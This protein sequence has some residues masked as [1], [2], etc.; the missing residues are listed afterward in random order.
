ML[1]NILLQIKN[2][3]ATAHALATKEKTQL[4]LCHIQVAVLASE[5]FLNEFN[6]GFDA[7]RMFN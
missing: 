5:K 6:G 4:S 3:V 2:I 1:I 7:M